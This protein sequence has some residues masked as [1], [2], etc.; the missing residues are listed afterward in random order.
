MAHPEPAS[1]E[2]CRIQDAFWSPRLETNR[3]VTLPWIHQMLERTGRLGAFDPS[4]RRPGG[5]G[6]PHV[7]WD[8]DVAK[9]V[10]GAARALRSRKD[11]GLEEMVDQAA[12]R[13]ARAQQP[14]GYLNTYFTFVEPGKRWT[15]LRDLHELYCAGHLIEA[16]I[17][18]LAATGRTVLFDAV[19]RYADLLVKT[20][21]RGRGKIRGY[22]GHQEVELALISLYRVTGRT[23]YLELA[24][25]FLEERGRK[26][27]FFDEEARRRG[28]DP[29]DWRYGTYE[30]CQAHEPPVEQE[31]A[32]GHAVRALYMYSAMADL[33]LETGDP[34]WARACRRLW[35]SVAFRKLYV[36]G[37]VGSSPA[38][39][40]FSWDYDL[41][42]ET[43]YAETC[44]AAAFLLFNWRMFRLEKDSRYMD[45]L[46]R[47]LYNGFLSG[48][49]LSGDRFFYSNP[50]A[51]H[52]PAAGK[53][54][55]EEPPW[56]GITRHRL[57]WFGCACC[58]PNLARTM[59]RLG[60][61]ALSSDPSNIW[62]HLYISGSYETD[63]KGTP[64]RIQI[65]TN[66][67]W[68][69][70]A[71]ITLHPRAPLKASLHLRIPSW[72]REA[73]FILK[74][75]RRSAWDRTRKGYLTLPGPWKEGDE[76]ILY[77]SMPPRRVYAHP[78]IRQAAGRVALARGPLVYCLE[79]CDNKDA[80]L[81]SITLS[82]DAPLEAVSMDRVFPGTKAIRFPSIQGSLGKGIGRGRKA[83]LY[84]FT[85]PPKEPW[86]GVALPYFL[87]DN[88]RPGS[89]RVWILEGP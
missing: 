87:W 17:E 85:P 18:H 75:K 13:I 68:D 71:A 9:W 23:P 56:D 78:R 67:P 79:S 24:R 22:P 69:G 53:R 25:F 58:P 3:K 36:T 44:A 8:S 16:G 73:D 60:E 5:P 27:H 49:S 86:R 52:D 64:V 38:N 77:L 21:G 33:A 48:V 70:K 83:P 47:T 2:K 30:Y 4:S 61:F 39:E 66:Y 72:C 88:R 35:E 41:P 20:F 81:E 29:R 26:P 37:G 10:E 59:E 51:S 84:R 82:R 50:L 1:L 19:V 65:V 45:A 40:G 80:L 46:E 6:S 63:V 42:D 57:G 55:E 14:D 74:N 43:A 7:F 89:M 15:N 12:R 31:E 34:A 28:E 54:G 11:P 76:V 32:V 62:I